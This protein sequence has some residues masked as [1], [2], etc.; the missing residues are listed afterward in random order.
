MADDQVVEATEAEVQEAREM[1]WADKDSWK[2]APEQWVDA[3]TFLEKGRHILPIVKE[4]NQRLRGEVTT[5]SDRLRSAEARQKA[6]DATLAAIEESRQADLEE[7]RKEERAKIT[8]ELEEASRDGDH[9][10]VAELTVQLAESTAVKPEE[11]KKEEELP[12][13]QKL[14]PEVENWYRLN[15]DFIKDQRRVALARVVAEEMRAAG[16]PSLGA[17]FLDKVAAEVNRTLG[18]AKKGGG[19]SKVEGDR[20]SHREPGGGGGKAY[21]DLPA[22]AKAA[23]DKMAGRLVGANRAHKTIE[24]WRNSYA[25]QYFSE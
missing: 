17:A 5:L 11:K 7:A 1:G 14:H 23:C 6:Q 20:G 13:Q 8:A 18:A 15:P 12:P 21:A 9:R 4:Q 16:E 25:K 3:K 24:S 19:T 2:G 10:R 22:D